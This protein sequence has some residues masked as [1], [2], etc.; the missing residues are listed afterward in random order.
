[1]VRWVEFSAGASKIGEDTLQERARSSE[2]SV[3]VDTHDWSEIFAGVAGIG[4]DS[5]G[6]GQDWCK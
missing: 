1:M 3:D 5:F 6:N 2:L 4:P